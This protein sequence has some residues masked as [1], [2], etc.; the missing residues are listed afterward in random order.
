VIKNLYKSFEEK[1]SGTLRVLLV[2]ATLGTLL[3][4]AYTSL[5]GLIKIRATA[6]IEDQVDA[7]AFSAVEDLLFQEQII[8]LEEK[9]VEEEV[10]E[11]PEKIKA[12]HA[13]MAK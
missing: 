5:D 7:V 11:V 8:V 4:A 2:L 9:E 1:Y 6:D 12:I 3:F 13:S 10:E